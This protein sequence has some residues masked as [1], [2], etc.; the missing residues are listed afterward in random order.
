MFSP[1]LVEFLG[2][3]LL[4]GAV[5]FT[6]APLLIV[7]ALAIAIS[8]GGKI[9]GGHFNPAVTAWALAS[10]KIGQAKAVGYILAQLSAAVFIWVVGSMIKV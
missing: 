3:S 1:T 2:T 8:L 4:V 7:S 5:S 10:G 9:S 6:G